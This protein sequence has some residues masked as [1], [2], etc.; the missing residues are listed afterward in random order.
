MS[1]PVRAEDRHVSAYSTKEKVGRLLWAMVQGTLYR[2]SFHTWNRWRIMLLNL[3]GAHV[4]TTC[5]IR[6]TSRVECPWNLTMGRN[7][8]LGD[9]S[10]A[11]CLG[12]ITIGERVS[13]SQDAY[14]CAGSHDYARLDL[15]LTRPPI[16]IGSDVWVAAGAFVGPGVNVGEGCVIGARAV[17]FKDANPWMIYAG[18][19]A[20]PV[21]PRG[22]D[23]SEGAS[24]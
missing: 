22:H 3:F 18:N 17:V 1:E 9:R 16:T 8:C 7:G 2:Y 6:R 10:W 15:P 24:S 12:P 21:K 23:A 13:V 19:P 5:I 14:L 11:Y 4:D 20:R